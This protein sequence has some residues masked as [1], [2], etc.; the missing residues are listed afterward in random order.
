MSAEAFSVLDSLSL[1]SS[2]SEHQ[3]CEQNDGD[4]EYYC[5]DGEP[6]YEGYFNGDAFSI[7]PWARVAI[8][9]DGTD[10]EVVDAV[11][12]CDHLAQLSGV[13]GEED[14]GEPACVADLEL[15]VGDSAIGVGA[16]CPGDDEC[17]NDINIAWI[18]QR[19]G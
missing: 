17:S 2:A 18:I 12:G 9:V 10:P 13:S 3:S 16:S 1:L 7:A 15:V 5:F 19:W 8:V 11:G 14:G 4:A 6:R